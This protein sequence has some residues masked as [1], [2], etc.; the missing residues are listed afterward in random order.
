MSPATTSDSRGLL[1]SCRHWWVGAR[2]SL[3]WPVLVAL[4]VRVGFIFIT[5]AYRFRPIDD[6]FGFGFEMGRIARSLALGQGFGSPFHGVTG[7]TAWEPPLYPFIIA[8]VFKICGIYTAVSAFVLLCINAIFSAFTCIP[9]VLIAKRCFS[10]KVGAWSSWAWALLPPV[11][12]WSTRYL[13]ETSLAALLL[14]IVFWIT[15]SLE[16]K[17]GLPPWLL[18][19][20]LW[21][22]LALTNTSLIA[23]L[24]ASGIWA[25][26]RRA[27]LGERSL[28]GILL[29]SVVFAAC[30]TPWIARDYHAFGRFIFIRSNFGA[31]LRLGNGPGADGTWMDY[32]H[33]TKNTQ[34][35]QLY[36]QIGEMA[37]VTQRKREAIAFIKEDYARFASLCMRR[38]VYF[39]AGLPR[40]GG[41]VTS[42]F[43]NS[44]YLA[45]SVL[46]IWGLAA[47]IRQHRPGAWLFFWLM[48][49]YPLAYY[50]AFV[51]PRYRHA[52]E[53]ELLIL[54]V[55]A[56]SEVEFREA[57]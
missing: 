4:V 10:E 25:W 7:P 47:A 15:L 12:F 51:L 17:D 57:S 54:I 27:K 34:Q 20:C 44:L 35:L 2:T 22:L 26:R 40:A 9:I 42:L 55:Y 41:F 37:Y 48:M 38:F 16:D 14:A 30:I 1:T 46:A 43:A 23:F 49:L 36:R 50:T 5:H 24:P 33:P 31:E 13:W 56:I 29:A 19:G 53:P 11:I 6:N 45:S 21:G 32:L 3:L 28:G 52:I 18:W 8:G 39:W